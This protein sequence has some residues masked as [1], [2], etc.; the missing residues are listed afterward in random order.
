MKGGYLHFVTCEA[1]NQSIALNNYFAKLRL[2]RLRNWTS[3]AGKGVQAMRRLE[4]PTSE[5]LSGTGRIARNEQAD[6]VEIV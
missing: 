1:V 6:G 4:H 2:P 3:R 5:D